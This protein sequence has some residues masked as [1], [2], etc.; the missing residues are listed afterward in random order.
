MKKKPAVPYAAAELHRNPPPL[1][2]L[3][4]IVAV[5]LIAF[6]ILDFI[7]KQFAGLPGIVAWYPPAGLTYA[8]LLVFGVPFTPAVTIALFLSSLFIY[9]MRCH[10]S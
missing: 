4:L 9:R 2:R 6:I 3:A 7:T 5:Y 8:L 1:L 10:R